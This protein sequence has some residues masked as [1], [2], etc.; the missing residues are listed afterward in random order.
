MKIKNGVQSMPHQSRSTGS[1]ACDNSPP[2]TL[3]DDED[4]G[5]GDDIIDADDD[6][7]KNKELKVTW[8]SLADTD[9]RRAA[10]RGGGGDSFERLEETESAGL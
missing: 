9:H 8:R 1:S 10:F 3:E 5:A 4:A 2:P 7:E 6:I